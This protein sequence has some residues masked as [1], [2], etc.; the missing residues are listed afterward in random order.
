[1]SNLHSELDI[2]ALW[3]GLLSVL[4]SIAGVPE[5]ILQR[6]DDGEEHGGRIEEEVRFDGGH[7]SLV[8]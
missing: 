8:A 6:G 3:S 5:L 4:R 1:M 2:E 7:R